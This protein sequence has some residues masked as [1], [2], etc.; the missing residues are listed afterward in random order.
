MMLQAFSYVFLLP[1]DYF[2]SVRYETNG[3]ND[4]DWLTAHPTS[5]VVSS[6]VTSG[7]KMLFLCKLLLK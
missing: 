2:S 4:K 7:G 5:V 1:I 3:S 6:W